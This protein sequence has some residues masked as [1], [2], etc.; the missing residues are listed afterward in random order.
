ML[1]LDPLTV[2]NEGKFVAVVA[3]DQVDQAVAL[4]QDHPLG[5][6]A[7]LVGRIT[8]RQP[9]IAELVTTVGGR[10]VVQKPY[11]EELPRIC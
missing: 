3:E 6:S 9:A 7:A 1:G 2:A 4:C 8:D 5:R 10:R 11:G